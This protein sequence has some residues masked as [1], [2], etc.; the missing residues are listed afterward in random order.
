MTWGNFAMPLQVW[1][2]ILELASF[3]SLIALGFFIVLRGADLFMFA[4]G[5]FAMFAAM[6]GS[7]QTIKQRWPLPIALLVGVLISVVVSSVTENSIVRPIH[8]RTGGK[9]NPSMIAIVALH[10]AREQLAGWLFGRTPLPCQQFFSSQFDIGGAVITGHTV[11]LFVV[12]LVFFIGIWWWMKAT[13][14]GWM[15]RAV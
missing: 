5:L 14:S 1:V 6:F 2:S 10:L 4:L 9:E 11:I 7:Y 15:L 8:S 3:S 13:P 12:T